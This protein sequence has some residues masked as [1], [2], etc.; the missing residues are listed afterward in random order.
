MG[1]LRLG[2]SRQPVAPWSEGPLEID[3]SAGG[4]RTVSASETIPNLVPDSRPESASLPSHSEKDVLLRRLTNRDIAI[5]TALD[6]H[7]YLDQAQIESLFFPSARACQHRTAWL[8]NQALVH[9]WLRLHPQT[10]RRHPSVFTLSVRGA[11]LL[12]SARGQD[13]RAAMRRSRHA[14]AHRFHLLHDLEANGFFITVAAASRGLEGEGLYHWIG[15]WG[16]RET[17]RARG[18]AFAPDGWGQYLSPSGEVVLLL[19]W[20]RGTESPQRIAAK[21]TQYI[22]Y[23]GGRLD[24][25]LSNVLFVVGREIREESVSQAIAGQLGASRRT[26]CAFWTTNLGILGLEGPL[27]RIWSSVSGTPSSPRLRLDELPARPRSMRDAGDCIGKPE[28]WMRRPG[29]GERA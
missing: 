10:W 26:T 23:F 21:A 2:P 15:E 9:R 11:W 16:C 12:A 24:A 13:P 5:L 19:E 1:D 8:R 14:V 22:T 18:A 29:G 17:Y 3:P 7:R 4:S 28:W 6:Q 20:D 27:G 25:H